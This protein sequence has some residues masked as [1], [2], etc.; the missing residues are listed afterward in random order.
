MWRGDS[1]ANLLVQVAH[2]GMAFEGSKQVQSNTRDSPYAFTQTGLRGRGQGLAEEPARLLWV[3]L[4]CVDGSDVGL[5]RNAI[6]YGIW[7][8]A[9]KHWDQRKNG[10]VVFAEQLFTVATECTVH[11]GVPVLE[12]TV[13]HSPDTHKGGL[14]RLKQSIG[15]SLFAY[16]CMLLRLAQE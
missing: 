3:A 12:H 8:D 13:R 2:G 7:L 5:Q 10:L 16:Y 9:F 14:C 1:C 15:L 6:G 11:V 4:S